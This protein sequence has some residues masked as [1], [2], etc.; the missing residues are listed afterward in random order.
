M[1][2]RIDQALTRQ[3]LESMLNT[4]YTGVDAP[5]MSAKCSAGGHMRNFL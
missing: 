4:L 1:L 5:E 3:C 2:Y